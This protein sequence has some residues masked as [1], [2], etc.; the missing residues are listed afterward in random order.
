MSTLASVTI[1]DIYS[2]LP[3]AGIPGRLFFVSTGTNAGNA[4]YDTGLAWVQVANSGG[5]GGGTDILGTA[6]FSAT[7]G[8]ISGLVKTGTV[9]GVT[10]TGVGQYAVALSGSPSNYIVQATVGDTAQI[11]TIQIDPVS[12]YTSSGFTLQGISVGGTYDPGLV[13]VTVI[14]QT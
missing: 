14:L 4:Y 3:I 11:T 12:S 9:T 13:F 8:T 7:G 10:R 2:N 1:Y 5:G 6:V